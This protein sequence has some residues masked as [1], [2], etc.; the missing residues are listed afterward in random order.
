MKVYSAFPKASVL[1]KLHY[2]VVYYHI[3]DTRWGV[4]LLWPRKGSLIKSQTRILDN[5]LYYTRKIELHRKS[6]KSRTVHIT[7]ILISSI[8]CSPHPTGKCGTRPF[9]G[10]SGCRAGAHTRPAFPKMPTAPS[11]L[12]AMN[13]IPQREQKPGGKA[14]WSQRK[15]PRTETPSARS[16][17]QITRPAQVLPG[18]WR[19]TNRYWSAVFD[20]HPT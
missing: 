4:L 10:G 15:S 14:P 1:L 11:A 17:P 13:P 2:L 7:P 12:R 18:N 16:V 19:S 6:K 8:C 9:Y 3:L 20:P 5:R